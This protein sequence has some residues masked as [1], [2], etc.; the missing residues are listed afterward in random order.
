M[1]RLGGSNDSGPEAFARLHPEVVTKEDGRYL[2]YYSWPD[3]HDEAGSPDARRAPSPP[4]EPWS[5]QAG[6]ADE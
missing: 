6:P 3:E 4:A 5:P 1:R 2:I